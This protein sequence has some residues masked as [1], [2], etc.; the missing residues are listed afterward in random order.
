[1]RFD[2]SPSR[3]HCHHQKTWIIDAGYVSRFFPAPPPASTFLLFKETEIA[4][5]GG[6]NI[7]H[8]EITS[9]EHSPKPRGFNNIHDIYAEIRGPAGTDV[10]HCFVQR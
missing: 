9:P 7:D 2:E 8:G 3:P 5:V 1:M 6:I 4:F 10:F